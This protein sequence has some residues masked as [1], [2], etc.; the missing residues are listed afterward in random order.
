MIDIVEELLAKIKSSKDIPEWFN[1]IRLGV[2]RRNETLRPSDFE[3]LN[4]AFV[5]KCVIDETQDNIALIHPYGSAVLHWA[6]L[7]A[8]LCTYEEDYCDP[9]A[10][11]LNQLQRDQ[12]FLV[13]GKLV[14]FVDF[15]REKREMSFLEKGKGKH[16][17]CMN[18]MPVDRLKGRIQLYSGSARKERSFTGKPAIP[19]VGHPL[20]STLYRID[21]KELCP[22]TSIVVVTQKKDYV[23][24]LKNL[25]VRC[26]PET[27]GKEAIIEDF[28]RAVPVVV[29]SNPQKESR[30][31][32]IRDSR[33]PMI[34]VVSD[35]SI[36][37][38]VI[39]SN[40]NIDTLIVDGESKLVSRIWELK[41]LLEMPHLNNKILLLSSQIEDELLEKIKEI[42]FAM[43]VWDSP[44]VKTLCN[45]KP[46]AGETKIT[47]DDP[48]LIQRNMLSNTV[49]LERSIIKIPYPDAGVR[50]CM[51]HL[52]KALLHLRRHSEN[53]VYGEAISDLILRVYRFRN[54]ILSPFYN[55]GIPANGKENERYPAD[56]KAI[57]EL[58]DIVSRNIFDSDTRL[59]IDQIQ[60]NV[61]AL[62]L[63]F[64]TVG[65]AKCR[66]LKDYIAANQGTSVIVRR[67][68]DAEK[69]EKLY[70]KNRGN[71]RFLS[72]SDLRSVS[73][74]PNLIF[75]GWFGNS[76]APL[77]DRPISPRQIYLLYEIEEDNLAIAENRRMTS[78][79]RFSPIEQ[80]AKLL[81]ISVTEYGQLFGSQ[82]GSE[83]RRI[84]D[85][86]ER[87]ETLKDLIDK[88]WLKG[89]IPIAPGQMD[90]G[91]VDAVYV[92][93]DDDYCG[94]F[95]ERYKAK[96]LDR[97]SRSVT[98]KGIDSLVCG[99]ELLFLKDERR[100]LFE[101]VVDIAEGQHPGLKEK[102]ALWKNALQRL[103]E[104]NNFSDEQ[105]TELL[106]RE[107]F[108]EKLPTVKRWF[109]EDIIAPLSLA[110]L[111]LI[112]GKLIDDPELIMRGGEICRACTKLRA[113]HV[114]V[115]KYLAREIIGSLSQDNQPRKE[116]T[117][118]L[119][120]NL[121]DLK[122]H[123]QPVQIFHIGREN[124]KVPYNMVNRLL[125]K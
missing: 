85:Q 107:G 36:A 124:K 64:R 54:E 109:D 78:A 33:P 10:E 19:T 45:H 119:I 92:V 118:Q 72:L 125:E 22:K 15:N 102:A 58:C 90:R 8:T 99:D 111:I 14:R 46:D 65:N 73:Y 79:S 103:K 110:R 80:K 120:E 18:R 93:F 38:E 123:V 49:S 77:L 88:L 69:A 56:A 84:S 70:G 117:G 30:I 122:N 59:T 94:F 20:F 98:V 60:Q 95:T 68:G 71:N 97:A 61:D 16:G 27:V 75:S 11:I 41:Q 108:S 44:S 104:K 86:T 57:H 37:M 7:V 12:L 32:P 35:L 106:N 115:G 31:L 2:S 48:F 89:E 40:L 91:P 25:I 1:R 43:W 39:R 5:A 34:R 6:V 51:R 116:S 17:G 112:L 29:Q 26:E 105:I 53:P 3:R 83:P 63:S 13:D 96:V 87:E 52:T 100:D 66:L 74:A 82:N 47:A 113:L 67:T 42:G 9:S 81:G 23:E 24:Q 62:E 114:F 121:K 76:H 21:A 50:K 4:A 101:V 55:V 28:C